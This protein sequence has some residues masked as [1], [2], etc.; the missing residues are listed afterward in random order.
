M[1]SGI[2]TLTSTLL[3][4]RKRSAFGGPSGYQRLRPIGIG[5]RIGQP[6]T[7]SA[8]PTQ[9]VSAPRAIGRPIHQYSWPGSVK[10]QSE[11]LPG[12]SRNSTSIH[13]LVAPSSHT[14]TS[15]ENRAWRHS[16]PS[17]AS[18]M[19]TNRTP[20]TPQRPPYAQVADAPTP[21]STAQTQVW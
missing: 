20:S 3:P 19:W 18:T 2:S 6:E 15:L 5:H 10:N 9:W 1:N 7:V 4:A 11:P 16:S 17:I 12:L 13:V 14:H 8:S 21:H